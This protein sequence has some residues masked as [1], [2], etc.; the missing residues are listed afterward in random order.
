MFH[1]VTRVTAAREGA[2]H[3]EVMTSRLPEAWVRARERERAGEVTLLADPAPERRI[4]RLLG[5][6]IAVG[7]LFLVF[8]GTLI[9]VWDLLEISAARQPAS[10]ST[11]WIQAHGHAQLF[12]W[13]GTFMIGICLYAVPKFRGA[14]IRSLAVG[15]WML[16]LWAVGTAVRWAAGLWQW[17]WQQLAPMAAAV[18][19]AVALLLLWQVSAAGKS[20]PRWELWS[21]PVFAGL[22]G[23]AGTMLWQLVTMA[24]WPAPVI[25][26]GPNHWLLH[27]ALWLFCFPVAWGFSARILPAFLG[28]DQPRRWV[29]FAGLAALLLSF[30]LELGRLPTAAG[31]AIA[32]AV[33]LACYC[34]RI[35]E[36]NVRAPKTLGVN[37]CFP[38][39]V[40]VAFGWLVLSA[41]LQ[42]VAEGPGVQGASRH[43]FTV[44]FL[45]NLIL[46]VGPRILPSF[47][48]SRELW[49]QRLMGWSL[50]VLGVGCTLRVMSEPLAYA[51]LAPLFWRLLP[52]SALL[53]LSAVVMFAFN[54]ARSLATPMPAWFA[55]EQVKD[56]MT[57][58][59]YVTSYPATRRLLR[60]AGI[61]TLGTAREVPKSLTLREAAEAEGIESGVV[62]EK[63]A[64]FFEARLARA[65]RGKTT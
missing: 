58:Y 30:G 50:A 57:L 43:A 60:Q 65:L 14:A 19:V 63:L 51:D 55:R 12:G 61:R 41:V 11:G 5:G 28:L 6:F 1:A 13:V 48:N 10:A 24:R 20:R 4:A 32:A 21:V 31:A 26:P 29:V 2:F 23:L 8:P 15:W 27:A 25:P 38:W 17:H 9:G 62:V 36:P 54:M 35:F 34:L 22:L 52:V 53:E 42:L 49:S 45:A 46:S 56:S 64:E 33:L 16:A 3:H 44:G 37:K 18:Q 39:F 7:L 47:V 40:R 59:W